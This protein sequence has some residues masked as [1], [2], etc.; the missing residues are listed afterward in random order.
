[1]ASR[2]SKKSP[3]S[4]AKKLV[5]KAKK[6]A[7]KPNVRRYGVVTGKIVMSA[8][9]RWS[10]DS[11]KR[12]GAAKG[13]KGRVKRAAKGFAKAIGTEVLEALERG[14]Q[15]TSVVASRT[16]GQSARAGSNGA[17]SGKSTGRQTAG[18][19]AAAR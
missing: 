2:K 4:S 1:M 17:A 15:A 11:K 9:K 7:A 19:A 14:V 16:T 6:L 10:K 13:S 12:K 3:R 18:K 8:A 5:S